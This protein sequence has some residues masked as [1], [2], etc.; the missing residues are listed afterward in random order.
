[1]KLFK[2][3][4]FRIF[5]STRKEKEE[6]YNFEKLVKKFHF[7]QPKHLDIDDTLIDPVYIEVAIN[8]KKLF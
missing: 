5:C 7:I 2:L 3:K 6:D 1:M 4:F 8:S